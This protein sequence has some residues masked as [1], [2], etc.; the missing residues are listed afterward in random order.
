[1]TKKRRSPTNE[2][3]QQ[4]TFAV[5]AEVRKETQG[6]DNVAQHSADVYA[7]VIRQNDEA[8]KYEQPT[9]LYAE[10]TV[11]MK[12]DPDK[13]STSIATAIYASIDHTVTKR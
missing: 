4:P 2:V 7:E 3:V 11:E 9:E 1:V 8:V 13:P 6:P 12:Q 10:V 5:Y